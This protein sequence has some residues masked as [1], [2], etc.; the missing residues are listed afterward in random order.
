MSIFEDTVH[1]GIWESSSVGFHSPCDVNHPVVALSPPRERLWME[2]CHPEHSPQDP[3]GCHSS[4]A[5]FP[6]YLKR[7][8]VTTALVI[9]TRPDGVE[10]RGLPP[11]LSQGAVPA[12]AR[13]L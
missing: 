9:L 3:S 6:G 2:S 12:E 4:Q 11:A 13:C 7:L 1:L 5:A 10:D 8:G